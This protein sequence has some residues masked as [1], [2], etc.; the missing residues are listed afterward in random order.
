MSAKEKVQQSSRRSFL[1]LLLATTGALL[2]TPFLK[3]CQRFETPQ[4]TDTPVKVNTPSATEQASLTPEPVENTSTPAQVRQSGLATIALVKTSDREAGVRQALELLGINPVQGKSVLLKP[5][6]NSTD[7]APASSH[8]LT[9]KTLMTA[10]QGMGATQLTL[11]DRSGM[12]H[13]RDVMQK[14]GIFDLASELGFDTLSF[15]DLVNESDWELINPPGSHW[16]NGFPFA[17]PALDA[18]AVVQTCCLKPHRYGGHF[19]LSLKNTIGMVGKYRG[20]GGYN[21]MNELHNSA[22]QRLM[23]AETNLAYNP[24]LILLDGVEAFIDQG[25]DIGT[26]VPGNLILAGT[27]RIAMDV[28]GLAALRLLG[29]TG[30]A[31]RGSIFGQEQIARAVELKLGIGSADKIR[32]ITMDDASQIYADQI[33]EVLVRDG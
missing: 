11:A 21:Y 6:F 15:E 13:S 10:L 16:K 12:G 19:T 7:P 23:I 25:P 31:A 29:M 28:F 30:E 17:R 27:D 2:I 4:L 5:N 18:G 9:I 8:P 1:K 22:Y 33:M 3:A 20:S 32:I 24:A 14:L 26:K